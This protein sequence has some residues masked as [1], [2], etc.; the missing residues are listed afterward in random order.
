MINF[1]RR[2]S[3]ANFLHH[4]ITLSTIVI[5]ASYDP[6]AFDK[7]IS[8]DFILKATNQEFYWIF[9]IVLL[10]GCYSLTVTLYRASHITM[11]NVNEKV[12]DPEE[13]FEETPIELH[14]HKSQEKIKMEKDTA[15]EKHPNLMNRNSI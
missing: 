11:V 12:E 7:W 10:I 9:G 5:V 3:I 14:E 13:N 8:S 4:T 1:V 6:S 2:S 15:T